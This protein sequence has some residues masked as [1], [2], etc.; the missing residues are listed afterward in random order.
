MQ[1]GA[2]LKPLFWAGSS[3]KDLKDFPAEVQD[4]MGYALRDA[5]FGGRRINAKTLKGFTP[6]VE[7][8][9]IQARL[10]TAQ[11]PYLKWRAVREK[12]D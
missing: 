9:L 6:Q 12:E 10:K 3:R 8:R 5:Q 7:K 11:E 4:G 1:P 2:S